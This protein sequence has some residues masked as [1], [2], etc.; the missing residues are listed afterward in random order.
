MAQNGG[1][2]F[3]IHSLEQSDV[4]TGVG[5]GFRPKVFILIGGGISEEAALVGS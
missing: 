1:T 4:W 2:Q 5:V 3:T